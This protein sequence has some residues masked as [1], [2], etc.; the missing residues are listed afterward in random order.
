VPVRVHALAT[1]IIARNQARVP[2][3][4]QP[5]E[6]AGSILHLDKEQCFEHIDGSVPTFVLARNRMHLGVFGRELVAR[7]I[8]FVVEGK[9]ARSPLSDRRLVT[10]VATATALRKAQQTVQAAHLASLLSYVEPPLVTM[11]ARAR[12]EE[13]RQQSVELPLERIAGELELSALLEAIGSLGPTAVL[14]RAPRE[15]LRY[16]ES[17]LA[18][19]GGTLPEPQVVLTSIHGAKGREAKRVVLIT[20]MTRTTFHDFSHG[21]QHGYESENRVAYVGATRTLDELIII[22][23]RTR[24]HY[25]FPRLAE[26]EQ[27]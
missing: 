13:L 14:G 22:R 20:S 17:L 8:P 10:A 21:G 11:A 9:G 27:R 24:R 7:G 26:E 4:Y 15:E 12:V 6:K 18:R 25:D 1:R 5:N 19:N 3:E 16:L 2:K 23:P